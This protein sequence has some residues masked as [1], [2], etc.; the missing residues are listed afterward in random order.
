ML[1]EFVLFGIL[2]WVAFAP[3]VNPPGRTIL[4]ILFFVLMILWLVV[5]MTG[6]SMSGLH[7]PQR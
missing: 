7:F 5:G 1:F 3:P 4:M 6:F 2:G